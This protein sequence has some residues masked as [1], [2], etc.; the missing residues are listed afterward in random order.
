MINVK[1]FYATAVVILD[2]KLV[3]QQILGI[4]IVVRAAQLFPTMTA[5]HEA[6]FWNMILVPLITI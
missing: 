3:V 6:Q 5:T 4:I 1:S 2:D